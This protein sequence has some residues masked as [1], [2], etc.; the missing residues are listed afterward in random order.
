MYIIATRVTNL[1]DLSTLPKER[2]T[3]LVDDPVFIKI[4]HDVRARAV[5]CLAKDNTQLIEEAKFVSSHSFERYPLPQEVVD[6]FGKAFGLKYPQARMQGQEPGVMA[7]MHLDDLDIG[8]MNPYEPSLPRLPF[9][10]EEREAFK[11]DPHQAVRFLIML[12]DARI[13]QGIMFEDQ[14]VTNW[15]AGDTFYWDWVNTPHATFNTSFWPRFLIRLTG[16]RTEKTDA[17]IRGEY[18]TVVY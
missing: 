7:T 17:I 9:T 14:A 6:R 5:K 11:R 10:D 16:L 2:A 18:P 12:E 1:P 8:Y 15:K 3:D 4:K 13:G